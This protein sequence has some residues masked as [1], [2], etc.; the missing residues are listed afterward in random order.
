MLAK[1]DSLRGNLSM[2]D[3][4]VLAGA[5]AI[6]KAASDGGHAVAVNVSTG[7]G[8][9][10]DA[11]TDADSF[12]A[13]EPFADGFRNYLRTKASVKTEDMLVDKANLLGL[14]IPEMAALVGGMRALGAV[15]GNTGHG[16]LTDRPGTLSNDFFVNLLDMGNEWS[17]VD[18]SGDEEF[19]G[20][21]RATGAE[22]FRATRTDLVFGSN[23][24]LRAIAETFAE[25]GGE[26]RMID[27]F[28]RA[29]TKV[30]DADQFDLTCA[31]YHA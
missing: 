4:I 3:A 11:D 30:M 27:T 8:D 1:L 26:K 21:D 15:H 16:V 6:E 10:S 2:A 19:V 29:W 22:K 28:L 31:G 23:S 18:D 5:A 7:R 24:Q 25:S 9:A 12:D 20:R 17:V 14:S 13:L